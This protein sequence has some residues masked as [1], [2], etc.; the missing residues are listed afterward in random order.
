MATYPTSP[1]SDFL[2]WC[3]AHESVFTD[4]AAAIGLTPEQATAFATLTDNASDATIKQEQ[5]KQ[6][7]KVATQKV[8]R[9]I[10]D[11]MSNA[12]DTVRTIRAFA[13]NSAD[14]DVVYNTAQI[15]PPS[16]PTP[17]P[18]PAEPTDLTVTLET[19]DGFLTLRWK[20]AN[21]V[22]TSGTSYIIRRRL[23]GESEFTFI[24]VTGTKKY[25]DSTLIAGPDSVQYTVQGQRA[26]SAGPVS[27]IF[28]VNFGRLPTGQATAYV[29]SSMPAAGLTANGASPNGAAAMPMNGNGLARMRG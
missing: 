7:S 28:T 14:P 1:R 21:P 29:G 5:A 17:A 12:G 16:A 3:K 26:D 11:L 18:P 10:S 23:P 24:G 27:Q 20:A 4:N 15:P 22:G 13:E 19:S 25:V 2:D 8:N 6:T 9:A